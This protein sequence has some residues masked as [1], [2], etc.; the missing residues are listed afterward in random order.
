MPF[1]RLVLTTV[2]AAVTALSATPALA[3]PPPGFTPLASGPLTGGGTWDFSI[4]R[5]NIQGVKGVCLDLTPT[6]AD[7]SQPGGG[8][9]CIGGSL[10]AAKGIGDV[11][12]STNIG[13]TTKYS[14]VGGLVYSRA[15]T[16]KITFADGKVLK[17]KTKRPPAGWR[18]LLKSRVRYYAADVLGVTAAKQ[19]K[20][21]IYGRSGH[22]ISRRTVK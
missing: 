1:R 15:R 19:A 18:R 14:L 4:Q 20:I 12:V 2:T 9:G 16:V 5:T 3:A 13:G 10:H 21:A 6:P 22:R 11:A 17:L 7:G 8:G